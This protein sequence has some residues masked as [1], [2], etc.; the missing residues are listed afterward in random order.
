MAGIVTNR[1]D[2]GRNLTW[3]E[4]GSVAGGSAVI[5]SAAL[6]AARLQIVGSGQGSVP[7]RDIVAELPGLA[8]QIVGG[9]FDV[10]ARAVPLAG[11]EA[12]WR[13]TAAEQRVVITP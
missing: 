1:S 12:A 13:D 10:D 9:T 6:R 3:I 7:T 4:I 2:R 8:H 5:P 11:V